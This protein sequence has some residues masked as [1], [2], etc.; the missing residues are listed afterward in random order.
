MITVNNSF[1]HWLKEVDI[2]IYGDDIPILLLKNML[3]V[4][5]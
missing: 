1:A 5:R 4:Y 2:K 3:E